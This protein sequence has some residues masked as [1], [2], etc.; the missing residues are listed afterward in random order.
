MTLNNLRD[1]P[2][3]HQLKRPLIRSVN[4]VIVGRGSAWESNW[5]DWHPT[6]Q[7]QDERNGKRNVEIKTSVLKFFPFNF[8]VVMDGKVLQRIR[9]KKIFIRVSL[10]A[11]FFQLR[12]SCSRISCN[13]IPVESLFVI[14]LLKYK[15]AMEVKLTISYFVHPVIEF[16]RMNSSNSR[17]S[18]YAF[19]HATSTKP[20]PNI[21]ESINYSIL[22]TI[23]N[24]SIKRNNKMWFIGEIR[25]WRTRTEMMF[26]SILVDSIKEDKS[27]ITFTYKQHMMLAP[28]VSPSHPSRRWNFHLGL[29]NA[30]ARKYSSD[31]I[32]WALERQKGFDA[33]NEPAELWRAKLIRS[34]NDWIRNLIWNGKLSIVEF[35]WIDCWK[36]KAQ[37]LGRTISNHFYSNNF[38]LKYFCTKIVKPQY[39]T[40]L[41]FTPN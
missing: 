7:P 17:L 21:C 41:H 15:L 4:W 35:V 2:R 6:E 31:E 40:S 3:L 24:G 13:S 28:W 38:V 18:P 14:C 39:L 33:L 22:L 37:K 16:S 30:D 32:S 10:L 26:M 23:R 1:C 19:S 34:I 29:S 27:I 36:L 25:C 5:S 12:T 9:K 11:L 8:P 20:P